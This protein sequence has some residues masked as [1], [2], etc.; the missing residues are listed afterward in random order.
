[1]KVKIG[2]QSGAVMV[3]RGTVGVCKLLTFIDI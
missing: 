3:S 1:M 2:R